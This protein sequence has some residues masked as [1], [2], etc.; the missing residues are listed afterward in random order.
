MCPRFLTEWV[1]VIAGCRSS[2]N[3]FKCFKMHSREKFYVLNRGWG[4]PMFLTKWL[5]V[6]SGCRSSHPMLL[7]VF[8]QRREVY[9]LDWGWC[10]LMFLTEWVQVIAGCRSSHPGSLWWKTCYLYIQLSKAR[11][12]FEKYPH[13]DHLLCVEKCASEQKVCSV[14]FHFDGFSPRSRVASDSTHLSPSGRSEH[15]T[16]TRNDATIYWER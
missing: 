7:N 8:R 14:Q 11:P 6:I 1:Q 13:N 4:C 3:V 15:W 5:K 9:V 16:S 12:P 2:P 10:F